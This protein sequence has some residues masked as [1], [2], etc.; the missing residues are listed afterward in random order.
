[1]ATS[2]VRRLVLAV[3]SI[4]P[5]ACVTSS[6]TPQPQAYDAGSG[7][8]FD[9]QAPFD[10]AVPGDALPDVPDV[11]DAA[12]VANV[13]VLGIDGRPKAGVTVVFQDAGGAVVGTA[14]TGADGRAASAVAEGSML[15]VAVGGP[16]AREL[17]TFLGIK[18][19]DEIVALDVAP[20]PASLPS[21]TVTP[22]SGAPTAATTYAAYAGDCNNSTLVAGQPIAVPI[23][24]PCAKDGKAPVVALALDAN[25]NP[26]GWTLAGT[27]ATLN[28]DGGTTSVSNF[29]A[30]GSTFGALN[31][32]VTNVPG[33]SSR[34]A[35]V[36]AEIAGGVAL[37]QVAN[38]VPT[39]GAASASLRTLPGYADS[40]QPQV[41][42]T[43]KNTG[44]PRYIE[45]TTFIAKNVPPI[46]AGG[47][48]SMD[49]A[50]GFPLIDDA[51]VDT[52]MQAQ[53]KLTWTAEGSFAGAQ[54][55]F[56]RLTWSDSPADGG[57]P[58]LFG[59]SFVFPASTASLSAPVLP[60]S[61]AAWAPS[62]IP[63][64]LDVLTFFAVDAIPSYEALLSKYAGFLP[65]S[66]SKFGF[67][68][69]PLPS[70]VTM[71]AV[72]AYVNG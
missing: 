27:E 41:Q 61:L 56:A 52:T 51:I 29:P 26:V 70:G 1:M 24:G 13:T 72:F 7:P 46:A 65:R 62:A 60:A 17:V 35:L 34:L 54:A 68:S 5:F 31:L 63:P 45:S 25:Q 40:F 44:S 49:L 57:A 59:W 32:S 14:T 53:P 22:P 42:I 58:T 30:W 20:L 69:V 36:N 21:L 8:G 19:G 18:N 64:Y 10:G 67:V 38:P 37:H 2:A 66:T 71:R 43:G 39:E 47:T 16:G 50:Q 9:G 4:A 33:T 12:G 15:T 11:V 55:G 28:V 6:S 23:N 3:A 48:V